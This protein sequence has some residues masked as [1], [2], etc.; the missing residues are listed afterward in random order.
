MTNRRSGRSVRRSKKLRNSFSFSLLSLEFSSSDS[1][2]KKFWSWKNSFH[3]V[4]ERLLLRISHWF[5]DSFSSAD[6]RLHQTSADLESSFFSKF[7]Y[8]SYHFYWCLPV[9]TCPPATPFR[10]IRRVDVWRP[11]WG[12]SVQKPIC[13]E[14][15]QLLYVIL[16]GRETLKTQ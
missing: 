7:M 12:E 3:E 4:L 10:W 5:E 16:V 2:K 1:W 6:S 9:G 13:R 8:F 14:S 15:K 11:I